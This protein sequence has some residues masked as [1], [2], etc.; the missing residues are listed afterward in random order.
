MKMLKKEALVYFAVIILV[1][2]SYSVIAAEE[3]QVIMK[4]HSEGDGRNATVNLTK[5]FPGA[6]QFF[7][8][9]VENVTIKIDRGIATII[10]VLGWKGDELIIFSNNLSFATE[11]SGKNDNITLINMEPVIEMSFPDVQNFGAAPE[12]VEFSIAFFDPENDMLGINWYVNGVLME[13]EEAKGGKISRFI[14]NETEIL[15]R[16]QVIRD[17]KFNQNIASYKVTVV[18]NDS[19]NVKTN[20]WNFTVVNGSCVDAWDC[21]NWSECISGKRYRNCVKDNPKCILNFNKPSDEWIDPE[22]S[23]VSVG[24]CYPNWSCGEWGACVINYNKDIIK[25]GAIYNSI[26]TKQ[27]RVCYDKTYCIGGVGIEA[28]E[29]NVSV[30]IKAKEVDWCSARYIEIYNANNGVLLSRIR[31]SKIEN[32][33]LDIELSLKD[34]SSMKYCSYCFDGAKDYDETDVDCGGS[35]GDCG[36]KQVI[37]G[38][39]IF[40]YRTAIFLVIDLGLMFLLFR[41]I[42]R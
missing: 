13:Q 32:P 29:C 6:K 20:E 15:G 42:G 17:Q 10:P 39:D 4:F 22:C 2:V 14:F 25:G 31:K 8:S 21:G 9:R 12:Q 26:K 37:I 27:E 34:L 16:S 41:F 23:G 35:C 30:P 7:F 38:S 18:I 28:R 24:T 36:S 19:I 33:G 40:D 11:L 1:L 3:N 5:F